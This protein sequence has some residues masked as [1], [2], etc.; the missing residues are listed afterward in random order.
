MR[1][2]YL[3]KQNIIRISIL[4]ALAIILFYFAYLNYRYGQPYKLLKF[5]IY[6]FL[7]ILA[8]LIS[9]Q[10][11]K[12]FIKGL[13]GEDK[14]YRV[15]KKLPNNFSFISDYSKNHRAN[16]DFVVI[17]TTGIWTIE[18]KNWLGN[19]SYKNDSILKNGYPVQNNPLKQAYAEAKQIENLIL[20]SLN[21]SIPVKP[22]LVFSDQRTTVRFG[23]N[24]L[25]GIYVVGINW[26]IN[27]ITK[28]QH[29]Y[30]TNEQCNL[31]KSEIKKYASIL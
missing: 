14:V 22:I 5:I 16:I 1:F 8:G 27:I 10:L 19:I 9:I 15:L 29:Q 30:L 28:D 2:S 11:Q 25:E 18:V 6:L 13:E 17:G 21:L 3:F 20:N 24:K 23:L 26:L 12:R 4:F 31:I 7:A